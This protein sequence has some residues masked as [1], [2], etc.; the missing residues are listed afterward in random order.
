MVCAW[1]QGHG[2]SL[3]SSVCGRTVVRCDWDA[4]LVFP[5]MAKIANETRTAASAISNMCMSSVGYCNVG[6]DREKLRY[7]GQSGCRA[8]NGPVELGN[9]VV[10]HIAW[11][12]RQ[13]PFCIAD[14]H[15]SSV[16]DDPPIE[17]DAVQ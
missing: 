4:G 14:E 6:T 15:L 10:R 12:R 5:P 3:T 8:E 7:F 13:V 2:R 17:L 1:H 16:I 9:E 11:P